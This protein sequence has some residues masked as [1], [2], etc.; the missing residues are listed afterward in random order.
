MPMEGVLRIA[1]VKPS[2]QA[3]RIVHFGA[4]LP[5]DGSKFER[6][7]SDFSKH[8]ERH[9]SVIEASVWLQKECLAVVA[10]SSRD[11]V[12]GGVI[13]NAAGNWLIGFNRRLGICSVLEY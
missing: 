13:H 11:S 1:I 6:H 5:M 2:V 12:Y 7:M 4:G 9:E 8:S 3:Y 10:A